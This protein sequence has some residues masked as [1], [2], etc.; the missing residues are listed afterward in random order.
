MAT[1]RV[2]RISANLLFFI[3]AAHLFGSQVALGRWNVAI[4]VRS[5]TVKTLA[6]LAG[7][8]SLCTFLLILME[9]A[10]AQPT[11]PLPLAAREQTNPIAGE[12]ETVLGGNI[13]YIKWQNIVVHDAGRDGLGA[14]NGCH[15]VIGSRDHYGAG[16]IRP[17]QRWREQVDGNHI[18]VPGYNYNANSIGVCLLTDCNKSVPTQAQMASLVKLVR[19][20]QLT[21]QVPSAR[22]YLHSDPGEPG[23]PGANFPAAGFRAQLLP[24]TR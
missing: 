6:L 23:C 1:I 3:F 4:M 9:T 18:Y 10:P 5:R 21:C 24:S 22:V 17:T 2:V 19:A 15:F 12:L 20:L 11:V 16:V 13:Q 8:M 14:A 7:A